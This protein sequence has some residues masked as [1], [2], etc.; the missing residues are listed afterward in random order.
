[1]AQARDDVP[2]RT[3]Y[4]ITPLAMPGSRA[5]AVAGLSS[6]PAPAA[7]PRG[8][9][10]PAEDSVW[11]SAGGGGG[12]GSS[13]GSG[14]GKS[15][16]KG[17]TKGSGKGKDLKLLTPKSAYQKMRRD[18]SQY[19]VIFKGSDGQLRCHNFQAGLCKASNCK[20]AH[21]CVRCGGAHGASRCPELGLDKV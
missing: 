2:H 19:G 6:A 1:M 15:K 13:S 17:K 21:V 16:G 18:P 14:K 3:N 20:Y 7:E 8:S 12:G 9:K 10:R 4:F 5:H 11:A